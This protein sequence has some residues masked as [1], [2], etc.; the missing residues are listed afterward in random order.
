MAKDWDKYWSAQLADE[1]PRSFHRAAIGDSLL[2]GHLENLG[3]PPAW[4]SVLV[5][6]CGISTEPEALAY[7]GYQVVAF[8]LSQ[9]AT[10][11]VTSHPAT[12]VELAG[13][14]GLTLPRG[15]RAWEAYT[16]NGH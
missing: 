12:P 3:N 7:A 2:L 1:L 13:W 14:L 10:A 8:D 9:V 16:R 11:H 4:R 6:G 15:R 5:V